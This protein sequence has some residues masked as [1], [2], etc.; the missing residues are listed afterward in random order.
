MT[1]DAL[2]LQWRDRAGLN[3]L[4]FYAREGTRSCYSVFT[5]ANDMPREALSRVSSPLVG[6]RRLRLNLPP[7]RHQL[8]H[9]VGARPRLQPREAPA[10][11]DRARLDDDDVP[12]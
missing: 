8:A 10:L 6:D 12:G 3:R 4:P 7:A 5:T 2:H 1:R 11:G 9:E